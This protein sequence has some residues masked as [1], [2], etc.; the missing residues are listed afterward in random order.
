MG[1]TGSD[2]GS[3][4]KLLGSVGSADS[5]SGVSMEAL[6]QWLVVGGIEL[7][8]PTSACMNGSTMNF[9]LFTIKFTS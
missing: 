3:F 1:S 6:G 9:G 8:K 2:L 7:I 5:D 4:W